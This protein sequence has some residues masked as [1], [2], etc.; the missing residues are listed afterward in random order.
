MIHNFVKLMRTQTQTDIYI[1]R[2]IFNVFTLV[3]YQNLKCLCLKTISIYMSVG[4]NIWYMQSITKHS[5]TV[6]LLFS[7]WHPVQDPG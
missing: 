5:V 4:G 3:I 7:L 1:E 2:E 6:A